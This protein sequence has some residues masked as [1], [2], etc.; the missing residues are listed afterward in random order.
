MLS[1][2]SLSCTLHSPV[3]ST[4][5]P[6]LRAEPYSIWRDNP[7]DS[8]QFMLVLQIFILGTTI[9]VARFYLRKIRSHTAKISGIRDELEAL[10]SEIGA[11]SERAISRLESRTHEL[12]QIQKRM[13][14]Q[15]GKTASTE[16][17]LLLRAALSGNKSKDTAWVSEPDG[18]PPIAPVNSRGSFVRLQTQPQAQHPP[19]PPLPAQTLR[20]TALD[21]Y[22]SGFSSDV[23][24]AKTGLSVAEVELIAG[25]EERRGGGA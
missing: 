5:N 10:A 19:A 2:Q 7:L 18:E 4:G 13:A 20:V 17:E 22:K 12:A 24:A 11:T 21:L 6:E 8:P 15:P 23:I 14:P 25:L 16:Q 9:V 1:A 3:A